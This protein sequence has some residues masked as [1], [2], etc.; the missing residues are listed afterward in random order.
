MYIINDSAENIDYYLNKY[1]IETVD[2]IILYQG[3]L[4]PAYIFLCTNE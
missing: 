1:S 2:Y 4:L 3:Y